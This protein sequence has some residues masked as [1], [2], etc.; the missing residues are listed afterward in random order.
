M[1]IVTRELNK[2]LLGNWGRRDRA[3][4]PVLKVFAPVGAA[5]W[6]IHSMDPE[7]Q[8]RLYG[9]CDLGFGFPELG[10]VSLSQLQEIQLPVKLGTTQVG[11]IGLERDLHFRPRHT[12]ETYAEA[13]HRARGI[14]ESEAA[15]DAATTALALPGRG[16]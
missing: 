4:M 6:V 13:A 2:K 11:A 8:D 9:L 10:Y 3:S 7:E 1:E 15:L 12:M 16:R 5:T 14:T